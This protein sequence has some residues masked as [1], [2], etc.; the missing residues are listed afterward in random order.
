MHEWIFDDAATAVDGAS[1][2][3]GRTDI[4]ATIKGRNMSVRS[5]STGDREWAGWWGEDPPF[6]HDVFVLT[7]HPREPL[8]RCRGAPPSIS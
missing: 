5:A 7:H 2:P 3:E 4:G 8:G 6:H 1:A